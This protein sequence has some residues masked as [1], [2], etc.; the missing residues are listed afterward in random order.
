MCWKGNIF[1]SNL[2]SEGNQHYSQQETG[3]G[4]AAV[5]VGPLV[6]YRMVQK[7]ASFAAYGQLDGILDQMWISVLQVVTWR[8]GPLRDRVIT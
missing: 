2:V 8:H 4:T 7:Q 6:L 1:K 5:I 3:L